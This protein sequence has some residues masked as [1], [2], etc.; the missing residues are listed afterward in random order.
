MGCMAA[1]VGSE[2]LSRKPDRS[3]ED[4]GDALL[5]D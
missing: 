2:Y 1:E 3:M 5:L 4:E